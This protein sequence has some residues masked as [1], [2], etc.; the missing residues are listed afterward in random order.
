[1]GWVKRRV[2]TLN[3][4]YGHNPEDHAE[5]ILDLFEE[6]DLDV[7][8]L[9]ESKDYVYDFM[10]Q[11]EVRG[12]TFLVSDSKKRGADQCTILVRE[13]LDVEKFRGFRAGTG[14]PMEGGGWRAPMRP[15][16]AKVNGVWY[17]SLHA[18]VGAWMPGEMRGRRFVGGALRRA[19]YVGFVVRL[20]KFFRQHKR[21]VMLGDWNCTPDSKGRW[22]PRWL[23][24]Q[25]KAQIR[26]P[27]VGTGHGEIDFA[28]AHNVVLLPGAE[29]YPGP[30]D[31]KLVVVTVFVRED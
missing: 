9:Q 20:R 30:G 3:A 10:W 13:G 22:S 31:H 27:W 4:Q 5:K 17:V 12:H 21:V 6:H 1:M 29:T 2:G 15:L 19:A 28:I 26:R 14:W 7:L 16:G 11:A 8:C 23:V 18:P 24:S 25:V